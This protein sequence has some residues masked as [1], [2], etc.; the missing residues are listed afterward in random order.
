MFHVVA[1]TGRTATSF[2]AECF[3]ALPG[4]A[5]CHE[6]HQGNDS[7]ADLL[8]LINLEN[9]RVFRNP[10]TGADVVRTKRNSEQLDHAGR[11]VGAEV[12]IDVAYY[13]AILGA[14]ILEAHPTSKMVGIIRDCESFVRSVTWLTGTDP[15]PVGWP[16]PDKA[17]SA[18]ERF[19]SMG[20]IRPTEGPALEH[21]PGWGAVER[22]IW[23]WQ[24]TNS[25][26][27]DARDRWPNRVT[28]LDFATASDGIIPLLQS[29]LDALDLS[30]KPEVAGQLE[31]AARFASA[32]SN[33]RAGGYQIGGC[34]N[35]TAP[36]CEMLQAATTEIEERVN[37]WKQ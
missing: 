15:M 6:G 27:C 5:A 25:R 36:Q 35:W 22:N 29:I 23:L 33:K 18:R 4:I 3:N 12:V 30:H 13:N 19:I 16:Q 2:I 1:S 21:W 28:L 37:Q 34:Q 8:P 11:S 17:L 14:S 26:L 24:A 9:H 32:R 7:G 10:E 20:R 31:Y